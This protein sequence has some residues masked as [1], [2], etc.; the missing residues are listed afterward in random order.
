MPGAQGNIQNIFKKHDVAFLVGFGAQAQ[1]A[2]FKYADGPLFPDN[3]KQIY[4]TN[5][6]WDIGKTIMAM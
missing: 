4:L 5:N 2:V 3:L 6:T 1:L